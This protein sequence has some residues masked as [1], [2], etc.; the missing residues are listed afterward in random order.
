MYD[1]IEQSSML[2]T[3]TGAPFPT[4]DCFFAFLELSRLICAWKPAA[5][6]YAAVGWVEEGMCFL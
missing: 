6:A 2:K 1:Y 3:L 5:S 4:I